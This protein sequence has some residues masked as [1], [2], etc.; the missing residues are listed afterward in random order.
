MAAVLVILV[1]L[2]YLL[3]AVP[4]GYILTRRST[5]KNILEFG[6][7]NTGSTNVGRVAGKRIAFQVQL[8]DMLKGVIPVAVVQAAV[9]SELYIFP[10][11]FIFLVAISAILGHNFSVF[12]HFKGGKGVN[13]TLGASLLIAPVEVL[14]G[15]AVYFL[16]KR[17]LKYVSAGSIAL[18]ITLP[19]S[20]LI[21]Q[22]GNL[23]V[24]YLILCCFLIL[25]R[26]SSNMK[27][28][29]SGKENI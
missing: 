2:S 6:S 8:L 9:K 28:L 14:S 12:L 4:F 7:G 19:L 20:G 18:A 11:Y 25:V 1:L 23:L 10:E 24:Y 16:V 22:A 15:V 29:I 13:T 27:R 17:S 26:H 21:L 3:G 5:G